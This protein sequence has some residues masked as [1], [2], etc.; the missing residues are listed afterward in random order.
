[1]QLKGGIILTER[2]KITEMLDIIEQNPQ[3][4]RYLR[5]ITEGVL[6]DVINAEKERE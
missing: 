2:E 6:N 1:M 4:I 5:I 3:A